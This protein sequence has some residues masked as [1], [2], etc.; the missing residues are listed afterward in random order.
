M[1][2]SSTFAIALKRRRAKNYRSQRPLNYSL[3]PDSKYI[4][5]QFTLY[6]N[7]TKELEDQIDND[8]HD[9]TK[10]STWG[11]NLRN[12]SAFDYITLTYGV[13]YYQDKAKTFRQTNQTE[14]GLFRPNNYNAQ[15]DVVGT[16][17][18]SYIPMFNVDILPTIKDGDSY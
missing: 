8:L 13:D 10:F 14:A 18:L 9:T 7:N 12:S 11:F 17:L 6:H 3:N 4:D 5:T 15:S 1:T 16:Y 2:T